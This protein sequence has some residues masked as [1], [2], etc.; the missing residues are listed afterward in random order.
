MQILFDIDNEEKD[1]YE[2]EYMDNDKDE[3][4]DEFEDNK[5][6]KI[7]KEEIFR[8]WKK[9]LKNNKKIIKIK[10]KNN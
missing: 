2:E 1:V 6:I 4:K 10:D 9:I 7:I 8:G 5:K 3:N